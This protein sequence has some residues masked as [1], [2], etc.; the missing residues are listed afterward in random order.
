MKAVVFARVS[1]QE[2]LK[3]GQSIPAQLIKMREYCNRKE[4][5]VY[6]EYQIDESSTKDE[7]AKFEEVIDLIRNSKEKLALVIETIDRLQ[8][9]FKESVVLDELRKKDLVEIHFLR[10]NLVISINSNSSDLLRWDMGVMFARSYVLQLSDNVK[11]SIEQKL[12]NGEWIGKAPY[13][14]KNVTL[15]N[16]KKDIQVDEFESKILQ[17]IFE[18]YGTQ[19]YSFNTIRL[20]LKQ[21]YNLTF[22]NGYLDVILKNEFYYGMM[23]SKGKLYPHKYPRLVSKALFD[24]VQDIKKGH[25]KKKFK[26]AG[27]PY[28]Y[29]GL[30][31]CG[32]CGL[33]ITPEKQKGHVYY[34]CTQ[35]NG[36][37]KAVWFREEELTKQIGQAFKNLQ[38]PED[39]IEEIIDSLKSV[40]DGKVEFRKE[41]QKKLEAEKELYVTRREKLYLDRLDGRVTESQY[42]KFDTSFRERIVEL[43]T[44][45]SII[46]EAED[47]YYLT[48][49]YLL[50]IAKRAYELFKSSEVDE[51]RQL[52]KLVLQNLRIEGNLVKYSL[53]NP[54]DTIAKC[55][56]QQ[57]WLPREDSNL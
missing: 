18:W 37:H 54:F 43:D 17:K 13:G 39:V 35:Y 42:D 32:Q 2:Q 29:R 47:N 28:I 51:K 49:K 24:L 34:H 57:L 21:D 38:V 22:S 44:R 46:Q 7:R 41:E 56:E 45:M 4:L 15:E 12:R 30:L 11:R 1:T 53:L 10:E 9:S 55:N 8:R 48:S 26:Y 19:A 40:H 31:R 3:E 50:E 5:A 16:E 20:K 52:I 25:N 27:L 33:A 23:K 36:K 6:K 14:Y